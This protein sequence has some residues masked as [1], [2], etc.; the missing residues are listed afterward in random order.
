MKSPNSCASAFDG[1]SSPSIRR[2]IA[3]WWRLI[4]AALLLAL[5]VVIGAGG[6]WLAGIGGSW[7]YLLVGVVTT[8][9]PVWQFQIARYDLWDYDLGSQPTLVDVPTKSGEVP[10]LVLPSRQGQ[11]YLTDRRTGK[12]LFPVA[13]RPVP[14]GGVEPQSLAKTQPYSEYA[15]LDRPRLS[16]GTCGA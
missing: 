6:A 12:S 3:D 9:K 4:F 15:H 13:D 14:G 5:R 8:G 1:A 2:S 16:R 7:Y 11:I 10:A